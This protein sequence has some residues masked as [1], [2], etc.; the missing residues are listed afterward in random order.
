[1]THQDGGWRPDLGVEKYR[2]GEVWDHDIGP[3]QLNDGQV[4]EELEFPAELKEGLSQL[5]DE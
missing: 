2:G 1:M 5:D 4:E 3:H